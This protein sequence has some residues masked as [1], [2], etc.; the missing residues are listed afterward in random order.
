MLTTPL[1]PGYVKIR[2]DKS[3]MPDDGMYQQLIG[4]LLYPA[5]N[6][7][8]DI[9][10]SIAILSQHNTEPTTVD[11][12]EVKRVARYLK[13]TK[14]FELCL[15]QQDMPEGLIGFADADWAENR[16]D[17]KFNSGY[18]FQYYDASMS[19]S[20]RKQICVA[21]SSTEAEYIALA[22]AAQEAIWI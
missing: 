8:P 6:T 16:T 21:L 2:N 9:A 15:G 12:N 13:R 19:W 7:R 17:R 5:T 14:R 18:L 20:C 3:P 11:W 1:D 22:E 10:A 4:A